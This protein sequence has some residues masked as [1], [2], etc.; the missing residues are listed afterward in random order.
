MKRY[1]IVELAGILGLTET[2]IRKKVKRGDFETVQEIE[3]NRSV[4]KILLSEEQL[5]TLIKQTNHNK[6]VYS[7]VKETFTED[8]ENVI[9][10]DYQAANENNLD[11]I[12]QFTERYIDRLESV[13]KTLSHK[14]SQ[15]KL[16][17]DSESR[18]KHE[19]NK[20]TAQVTELLEKVKK[21]E[22]ENNELKQKLSRE[23]NKPFWKKKVL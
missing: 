13:Y 12:M 5:K 6:I 11:K 19:Y 21:L 9:S 8:S 7:T 10:A 15:I 20:L 16:I 1:K 2:A 23:R 17:E 14:D 22:L 4:T 18:T 3:Q